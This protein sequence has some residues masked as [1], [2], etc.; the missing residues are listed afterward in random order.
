MV[1]RATKIGCRGTGAMDGL[2]LAMLAPI[3]I[4]AGAASGIRVVAMQRMGPRVALGHAPTSRQEEG[5]I[6]C[7]G[8]MAL[9]RSRGPASAEAMKLRKALASS[10]C[11]ETVSTPAENR[12][13]S[14]NSL[15]SG[16]M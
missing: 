15:G 8:S 13:V 4:V 1:A 2:S 6:Q 14:C 5:W 3:D 10:F 12:T 7:H 16:P 11:F 9:R